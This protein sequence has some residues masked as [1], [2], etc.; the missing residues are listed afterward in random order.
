MRR[1]LRSFAVIALLVA[2]CMIVAGELAYRFSSRAVLFRFILNALSHWIVF[3]CMTLMLNFARKRDAAKFKYP[4]IRWLVFIPLH[5]TYAATIVVGIG[6]ADDLVKCDAESR[7]IYP[8]ISY[9]QYSLFYFTYFLFIFLRCKGY[10][11]E[12]HPDT[13]IPNLDQK[14]TPI[15]DDQKMKIKREKAKRIFEL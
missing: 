11:L 15:D 10:F 5:L 14:V 7:R 9:V 13:T 12:W 4:Q 1:E 8:R 3:W 6:A 2:S